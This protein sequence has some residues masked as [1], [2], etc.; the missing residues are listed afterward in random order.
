MKNIIFDVGNVLIDFCW[1][2]VC[3]DLGFSQ[4]VIDEFDKKMISSSYWNDMDEGILSAKDA[5]VIFRMALSEYENE[6]DAFWNAQ[7]KYIEE[8]DYAHDM[9]EGLKKKGYGVYLLSNYPK[10]MYELHWPTF[11]FLPIVDGYV[12]SA[13]EKMRKPDDRIYRLLCER[14]GL[15]PKECTFFDDRQINCDAAESVGM[16]GLLFLGKDTV[17]KINEYPMINVDCE[18]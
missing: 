5:E 12:V 8:Y 6:F 7:E 18:E 13:L 14:F 2:K 10:E 4:E 17:E 9:I 16:K 15:D 1:Q 3:I 11:S